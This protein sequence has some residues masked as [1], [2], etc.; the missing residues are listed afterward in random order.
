M[1][2]EYF[3]LYLIEQGNGRLFKWGGA[4]KR[5]RRGKK[6]K[7]RGISFLL[8]GGANEGREEEIE[9]GRG[10]VPLFRERGRKGG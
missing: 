5:L 1:G 2:R 10:V 9:G 7:R 8:S 6:K 3:E 4:G